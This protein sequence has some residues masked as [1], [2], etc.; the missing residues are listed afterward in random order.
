MDQFTKLYPLDRSRYL[1]EMIQK[2]WVTEGAAELLERLACQYGCIAYDM[3]M[4]PTEGMDTIM[5]TWNVAIDDIRGGGRKRNT[6]IAS[7]TLTPDGMLFQN[8]TVEH[9]AVTVKW[10]SPEFD[11]V[12]ETYRTCRLQPCNPG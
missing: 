4:F 11:D 8:G 1:N 9:S 6:T 2:N 3:G 7:A 12:I 5:L 10:N